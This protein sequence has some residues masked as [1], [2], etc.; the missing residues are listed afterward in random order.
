[1]F[2]ACLEGFQ[3]VAVDQSRD[4]VERGLIGNL[5]QKIVLSDLLADGA[6]LRHAARFFA[7]FLA[8]FFAGAAA[9]EG[10]SAGPS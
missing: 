3:N 2:E 8:A 7:V 9:L 4:L 10:L 1:M 6:D 5:V